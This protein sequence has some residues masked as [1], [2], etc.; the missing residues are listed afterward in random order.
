ML[1]DLTQS[2]EIWRELWEVPELEQLE[3][4][5]EGV[6]IVRSSWRVADVPPSPWQKLGT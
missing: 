4:S 6:K 1:W 2:A 3:V 5:G